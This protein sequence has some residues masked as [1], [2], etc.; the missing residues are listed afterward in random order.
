MTINKMK[1]SKKAS[2][3]WEGCLAIS[4][5]FGKT[6]P[7]KALVVLPTNSPLIKLAIRPKNIPIGA[8]HAIKSRKTKKLTFTF[9][10]KK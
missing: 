4:S 6:T 8:T 2:Y 9:F 5:I 7:Q 10:E 1:P 3:S